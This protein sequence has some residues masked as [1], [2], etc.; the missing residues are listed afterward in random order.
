VPPAYKEAGWQTAA[1]ADSV[2][3]GPWWTVFKDPVLDR[4]ERQVAISNQTLRAA[5][6]AF[7]ESETIVAQARAGYYPTATA[8]ATAT[9]SRTAGFGQIGNSFSLSEAASWIPDL[10]GRVGRTVESDIATAQ[11]N[12]ADAA[13]ARLAAQGLLATDYMQ[14]RVTDQLRR[15][16]DSAAA[17]Y[18]ESLRITRNQYGAGIVAASDVAQAQTQLA[19]TAAQAVATAVL[20]AQ[21]EHAIAV[22]IGRA[23]AELTIAPVTTVPPIPTIPAGLPAVLLERRPDIAAA[24]RLVAA[25][26][27]KIGVAETAF[28]PTLTLSADSGTAAATLAKLLSASSRVWSLGSD[29]A[30]T[31]FDAGARHAQVAEARAAYDA[32]VADYRQTVLTGFQQVED[33]L[34]ALRILAQEAKTQAVAV[35]ASQ[36]AARILFNQYKAGIVAYTNVVVAQTAALAS[37][38]TAVGLTQSRLVS[39]VGLI[40]ALGGGWTTAD[41]PARIKTPNPLLP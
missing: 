33:Q 8:G 4:L 11:A 20:R 17:A 24:E 22:L 2:K 15:L 27:A 7:R 37:A 34:A 28:F 1:P 30:Q 9:R 5:V 23:P 19:S 16:L 29:L 32:T 41:L 13:N 38:E 10:W 18:R 25:A 12:A 39:A 21:Y 35:T 40:E 36:E 14:L 26:N 6:A 31:V 3:R